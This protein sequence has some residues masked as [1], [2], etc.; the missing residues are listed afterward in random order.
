MQATNTRGWGGHTAPVTVMPAI[1]LGLVVSLTHPLQRQ[2]PTPPPPLR[3][4]SN[5]KKAGLTDRCSR[6]GE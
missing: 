1:K 6:F 2:E 3:Y 4:R 5:M